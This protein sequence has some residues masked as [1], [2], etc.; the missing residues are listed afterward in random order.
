MA[1]KK[2][3]DYEGVKYLWSKIN[4]KT[5]SLIYEIVHLEL[6]TNLGGGSRLLLL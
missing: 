4:Q 2:Y 1:T 6:T 3:L 5:D